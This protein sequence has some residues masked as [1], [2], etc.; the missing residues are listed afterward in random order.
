V[1]DDYR[2][3][4]DKQERIEALLKENDSFRW[5]IKDLEN[6]IDDLKRQIEFKEKSYENY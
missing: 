2:I 5:K 6:E 3:I 4:D 1:F